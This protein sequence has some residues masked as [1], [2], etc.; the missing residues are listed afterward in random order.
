MKFADQVD[1]LK[2]SLRLSCASWGNSY[3]EDK[4]VEDLS[5]LLSDA[6]SSLTV[7]NLKLLLLEKETFAS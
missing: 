4:S 5:S 1:I 3:I 6:L 7:K 2:L